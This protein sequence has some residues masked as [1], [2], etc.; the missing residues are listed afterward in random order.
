MKRIQNNDSGS[1][2]CTF[3]HSS[4]GRST[5]IYPGKVNML[6]RFSR[7][8]RLVIVTTLIA[9]FLM[10]WATTASAFDKINTNFWGVAIKGYDTVAY[11]TEG[12]AVKGNS[13]FAYTWNDAKWYFVSKENRGLFAEDPERYSPQ[14]GGH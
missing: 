5:S 9:A 12:R 3:M 4:S 6:T 14:Y 2:G 13:E 10:P 1:R 8:T 7:K 11:H